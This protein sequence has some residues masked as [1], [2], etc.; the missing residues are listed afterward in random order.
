MMISTLPL[1]LLNSQL[2]M[3]TAPMMDHVGPADLPGHDQ[4]QMPAGDH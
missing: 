2:K 1:A 4:R 3:M